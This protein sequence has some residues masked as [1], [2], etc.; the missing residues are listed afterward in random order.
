LD[1]G[2]EIS[3]KIVR[4]DYEKRSI[5]YCNQSSRDWTH[6]YE[7]QGGDENLHSA[8]CGVFSMAFVIQWMMGE[9]VDIEALADFSKTCGGRGDDGTDR[10]ELLR[11]MVEAGL[12]EKYGFRYEGDG[13]VNDPPKLWSLLRSGGCAMGNLRVGHIVAILDSREVSGE[14]QILI[15]DSACESADRRIRDEVREVIPQSKVANI[16]FNKSGLEVGMTVSHAMYWVP[17][18][19]AMDVNL[20]YKR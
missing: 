12:D 20:L 1:Y 4:F 19:L 8:G 16:V 2:R 9:E 13:L 3:P 6:P 7:Y 14:K 5:R 11:G 15:L 18:L 17:L 10:P